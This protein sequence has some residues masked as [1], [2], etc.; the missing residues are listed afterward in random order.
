M[1]SLRIVLLV[2]IL[3]GL[4]G[5]AQI[6]L[7]ANINNEFASI[8]IDNYNY[9]YGNTKIFIFQKLQRRGIKPMDIDILVESIA[10]NS[11][12]RDII[13]DVFKDSTLNF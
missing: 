11:K 8:L 4:D 10:E 1:R 2:L 3:A 13:F 5:N 6:K 7:P 12:N 9:R